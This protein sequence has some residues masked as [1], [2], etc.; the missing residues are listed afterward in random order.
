MHALTQL[1]FTKEQQADERRLQKK[2]EYALHRQRLGE[3]I[4]SER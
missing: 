4:A 3:H 2:G 1:A